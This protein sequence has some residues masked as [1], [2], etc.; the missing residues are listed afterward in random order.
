MSFDFSEVL[1]CVVGEAVP[2]LVP[3]A[4]PI[5]TGTEEGMTIT[6]T[7][8]AGD[9]LD[10]TI[11]TGETVAA[12]L[13]RV[14]ACKGLGREVMLQALAGDTVLN[15]QEPAEPYARKTLSVVMKRSRSMQHDEEDDINP[16]VIDAGSRVCRIGFAGSTNTMLSFPT[17][18]GRIHAKSAMTRMVGNETLDGVLD[19]DINWSHPVSGLVTNWDEMEAIWH[20]AFYNQFRGI[21]PEN[22][23]V[24]LT[25]APL[26]PKANRE[27]SVQIMFETFNVPAL[28]IAQSA[29]LSMCCCRLT[30]GVVVEVGAHA[31]HIVPVY[32]GC[33]V[34]HAIGRTNV[35]GLALSRLLK[36]LCLEEGEPVCEDLARSS[37]YVALNFET[38]MA[39]LTQASSSV[40]I[41]C[42][43]AIFQ[44]CLADLGQDG[45][46]EVLHASIQKCDSSIHAALLR[47][48]L[49][50]GGCTLL[51]G[52]D[53]RLQKEM[54][55]LSGPQVRVIAPPEREHLAWLGGSDIASLGHFQ[56]KWVTKEEYDESGPAI[57]H[58]R[59]CWG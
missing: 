40:R 4:V 12:V 16:L 26:T 28:Y 32:Q 10:I 8:L 22:H 30:T 35:A 41:R 2:A 34:P 31:G 55:A 33:V 25:E 48:I 53:K 56:Q 36:K 46:H 6:T 3:C 14:A 50:A 59:K 24:L 13:Q 43:E 7:F 47:G 54:A 45:L 18:V 20:H 44:P 49:C 58:R 51:P 21:M 57:V 17:R 11:E 19:E 52:F 23:P 39:A 15:G 38:E 29:L 9:S 37:C 1:R 27:K 5:R 42:P